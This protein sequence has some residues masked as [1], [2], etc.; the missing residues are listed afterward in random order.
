MFSTVK[1]V[2]QFIGGGVIPYY[3]IDSFAL[4]TIANFTGM[5]VK[6][7]QI[8]FAVTT[9]YYTINLIMA[10][11]KEGREQFF[12]NKWNWADIFTIL[13]SIF[14]IAL[15]LVLTF[16]LV[17]DLSLKVNHVNFL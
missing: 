17:A 4:F 15:Y 12:N 1:V 8:L 9:F 2:A 10:Y 5:L 14:A 11:K 3:R 7:S 6:I 16:F 13:L